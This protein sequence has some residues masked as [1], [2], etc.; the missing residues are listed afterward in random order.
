[1]QSFKNLF[2]FPF[3]FPPTPPSHTPPL[4]LSLCV[5]LSHRARAAPRR[6]ARLPR[7]PPFSP[8]NPSAARAGPPQALGGRSGARTGRWRPLPV[9]GG[10][11]SCPGGPATWGG[12]GVGVPRSGV[13]GASERPPCPCGGRGE[14]CAAAAGCRCSA[15]PGI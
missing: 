15:R 14:P 13:E 2:F 8:Q 11:G 7:K 6:R 10:G 1:M 3:F 5:R 12:R 9:P 4:S